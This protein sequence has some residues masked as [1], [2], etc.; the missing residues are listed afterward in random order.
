MIEIGVWK[1]TDNT[2]KGKYGIVRLV[3]KG[4]SLQGEYHSSGFI[5]AN[6]E[7]AQRMADDLNG[8]TTDGEQ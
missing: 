3:A 5:Y 6:R 8:G 1:P 4:G 7:T 2:I